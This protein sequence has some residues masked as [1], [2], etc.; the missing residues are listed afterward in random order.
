MNLLVILVRDNYKGSKASCLISK[1]S[2]F[3]FG[4]F[5]LIN[6][7]FRSLFSQ[8]ISVTF[9]F[10][11]Y[12]LRYLRNDRK[13]NIQQRVII[14]QK[15]H[16]VSLTKLSPVQRGSG[17]NGLSIARIPR[18]VITS[19][20]FFPS[21][22]KAILVTADFQSYVICFFPYSLTIL[23]KP[24]CHIRVFIYNTVLYK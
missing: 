17:L 10:L 23:L 12:L 7:S 20:Q 4:A 24:F 2:I 1:A 9:F 19:F 8:A 3:R 6:L 16:C 14:P 18:V 21:L 15:Q 5:P 13:K 22:S 11:C